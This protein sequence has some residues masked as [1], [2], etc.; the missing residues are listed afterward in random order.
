M[1]PKS[2]C[3][4]TGLSHY[5]VFITLFSTLC[6]YYGPRCAKR[7]VAPDHFFGVLV[8]LHMNPPNE[9]LVY[10]LGLHPSMFSKIT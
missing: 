8:T 2:A 1:T 10:H 9:D 4:Y 5:K 6:P 7:S 3:F